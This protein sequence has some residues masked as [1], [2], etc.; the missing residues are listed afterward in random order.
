MEILK[1]FIKYSKFIDQIVISSRLL[2]KSLK[3]FA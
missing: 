3:L 2:L 1:K